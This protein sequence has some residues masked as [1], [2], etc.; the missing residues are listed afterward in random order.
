MCADGTKGKLTGGCTC[1][2]LAVDGKLGPYQ[3][4]MHDT[5]QIVSSEKNNPCCSY[6]G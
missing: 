6:Q 1:G 2:W 3:I 4:P 5:E